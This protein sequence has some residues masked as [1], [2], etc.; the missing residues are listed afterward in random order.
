MKHSS[1]GRHGTATG[2]RRGFAVL[3]VLVCLFVISMISTSVLQLA[4]AQ[5]RQMQREQLRLQATWLAEA[6]LDRAAVRLKQDTGY[7]GEVWT[8]DEK[9]FASGQTGSVRI[10]IQ[11]DKT[12]T[13]RRIV[14]VVADFPAD[15]KQR[16]RVSQ[17]LQVDL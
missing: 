14:S 4:V 11:A 1:N 12:I 6:A 3:M 2:R 9:Q 7:S 10:E 5:R 13:S 8:V 16:A 15:T 17:Q